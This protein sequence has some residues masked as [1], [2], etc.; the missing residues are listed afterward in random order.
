M[1]VIIIM[2]VSGSGKTSIGRVLAKKLDWIF[3]DADDFHPSANVTK[4]ASGQS[5]NDQDRQPWLIRLNQEINQNP[6]N[7][8]LA[9]S[10]LKQIYR[11]ALEKDQ[12]K[13]IQWVY[14]RGDFET[15]FERVQNRKTHFMPE[16]LLRSQFDTLEEPENALTVNVS[17]TKNKI[18]NY[19]ITNLNYD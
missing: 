2:G 13:P 11:Q 1:A 9:C 8:I 3:M 6:R 19:L 18:I 15:I 5:L 10:A 7:I 16:S 17:W 14:L 12:I 4:M